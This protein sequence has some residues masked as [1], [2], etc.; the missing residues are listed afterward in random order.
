M[1]DAG[2]ILRNDN[3]WHKTNA[4]PESV[5]DRLTGRHEYLFLFTRSPRYRFDLD[6]VPVPQKTLGQVHN[7]P[8]GYRPEHP[9]TRANGYRAMR[10]ELHPRGANP[11]GVW[12][13]PTTPTAEAH[14]A[15][16]PLEV[17][18]R[19]ILAGCPAAGSV[20]D[21]FAGSG[22]TLLAA[23]QLGRASIGIE[24]NPDYI[25]IIR[26]RIGPPTLSFEASG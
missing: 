12:S 21:P 4:M 24:L 19:C 20:L 3:I 15:T 16:F 17:P 8:A 11:G 25:E 7:G 2:W 26:R 10:R 6:A 9:S 14:F 23:R 1:I 5:E 13:I 22:T 18:R